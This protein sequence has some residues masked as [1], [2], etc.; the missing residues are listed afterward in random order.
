MQIVFSDGKI[1]ANAL[2]FESE[3]LKIKNLKNETWKYC[4]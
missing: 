4:K 1:T 2:P 3:N